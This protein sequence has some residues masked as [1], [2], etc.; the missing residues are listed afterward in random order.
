MSEGR[1]HRR[2]GQL[3]AFA[4]VDSA[5]P[6]RVLG[7]KHVGDPGAVARIVGLAGGNAAKDRHKLT[8]LRVELNEFAFT[9]GANNEN[10][11][12]ILA[13][14]NIIHLE[15]T[16]REL[17]GDVGHGSTE[18]GLFREYPEVAG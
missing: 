10:L 14:K 12:S 18:T 17:H 4:P 8:G 6:E 16:G 7:V 13:R 9:L 11:F 3:E 5:A 15:G 2:I 1:L